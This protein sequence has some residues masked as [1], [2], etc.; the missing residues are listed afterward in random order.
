ML[1]SSCGTVA[2]Y[3]PF[4]FGGPWSAKKKK[5]KKATVPQLVKHIHDTYNISECVHIKIFKLNLFNSYIK[6]R[7]DV[8][9]RFS[10]TPGLL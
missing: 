4:F 2:L 10:M 3:G 6:T 9:Y 1:N 5:K 8:N 7:I